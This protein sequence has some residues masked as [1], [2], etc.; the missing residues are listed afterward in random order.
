MAARASTSRAGLVARVLLLLALSLLLVSDGR[1]PRGGTAVPMGAFLGADQS[2]VSGIDGFSSWVGVTVPVGHAYL[3]GGSWSDL[4]GPDWV[5]DPWAAWRSARS[6]RMLVLNVPM[7]APNEPPVGDSEAA[8]LLRRGAAGEQDGHFRT[9]AERLVERGATDTIIVL[10][11]EMNGTSY[12]GRCAPDP[13]AWQRYWRR[14]VGVM[15]GVPGQRFR[16]DFAPVRGA[17][18]IPWPQCYPGDDV[19][20]I[21][22][23]DSY[24]QRPGR[25]FHDFIH[26]PY[27]LQAHADFAAAHGK[28]MSYPEWGLFDY[29]DNPAYV[30]GMYVWLSTHDVTY[31]TISDYCPHGVWRCRANSASSDMYRRLF[32][33]S[34]DCSR[35]RQ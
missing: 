2:A 15:R 1:G 28:P 10:G 25:T 12:S 16:F 19:V 31:Q 27:G 17:Q 20:D 24:D 26:Q 18:A 35:G 23:M 13:A 11:W 6:A 8:E 32:G 4:E 5:L 7:V 30:R 34:V 3:P 14:I 21:V 33:V 29:G 9:L 22:G